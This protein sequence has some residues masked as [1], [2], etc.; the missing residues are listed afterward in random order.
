MITEHNNCSPLQ[1]YLAISNL[2]GQIPEEFITIDTK[3]RNLNLR[4]T[5]AEILLG[6]KNL[7]TTEKIG[8]A[9]S[10]NILVKVLGVVIDLCE[11]GNLLY[12]DP[13]LQKNQSKTV[14]EDY[15]RGYQKIA[16]K[17]MATIGI[18]I[19][20]LELIAEINSQVESLHTLSFTR[21]IAEE[22]AQLEIFKKN[23]NN[24]DSNVKTDI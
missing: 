1:R 20:D 14:V 2:Q 24:P 17:L 11:I 4:V 23:I 15:L 9:V 5:E 10:K 22:R 8:E 12:C 13:R 3:F 18:P 6:S 7:G 21:L 16:V 19:S